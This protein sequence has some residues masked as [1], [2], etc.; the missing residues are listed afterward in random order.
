MRKGGAQSPT[1]RESRLAFVFGRNQVREWI[2]EAV[3]G[4]SESDT[5]YVS[6]S[7]D[8]S[9]VIYSIELLQLV[10]DTSQVKRDTPAF[11][12]AS[13][14]GEPRDTEA[15]DSPNAEL[16]S[17]G[18][19]DSTKSIPSSSAK[20]SAPEV[21]HV[22]RTLADCASRANKARLE[23]NA[24]VT[25]EGIPRKKLRRAVRLYSEAMAWNKKAGELYDPLFEARCLLN[26]A[27]VHT[28]VE[29]WALALL[30][31]DAVLQLNPSNTKAVF[32]RGQSASTLGMFVC[33]VQDLE[34]ALDRNPTDRLVQDTLS[35]AKAR[36]AKLL[37]RTRKE[38]AEVYNAMPRSEIYKGV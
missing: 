34:D 21:L 16:K 3:R 13:S 38:F 37:Q 5:A 12:N 31:S 11:S 9:R 20:P 23:G 8:D 4:L 7:A 29:D 32:R 36:R 1:G 35:S 17:S 18:K 19:Q 28:K 30:C 24:V 14:A 25:T 6:E 26:T 10:R 27:L 2:E 15:K 22:S 33:A